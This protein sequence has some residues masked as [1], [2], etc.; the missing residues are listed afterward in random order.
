MTPTAYALWF[1]VLLLLLWLAWTYNRLVAAR[2]A[3]KEG[4]SGIDVQ[5]KRRHDLVPMLVDAVG[6][7]ARHERGLLERVARL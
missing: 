2:N 4:W 6:A 7:Y 1:V 5:L 3:I